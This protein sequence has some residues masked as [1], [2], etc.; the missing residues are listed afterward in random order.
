MFAALCFTKLGTVI[1][2]SGGDL[3]Y[4]LRIYGSCPALFAAFT[5]ILVVKPFSKATMSISIAELLTDTLVHRLP[6]SSADSEVCCSCDYTGCCHSQ[7]LKCPVSGFGIQMVFLVA[8]DLALTLTIIGGI[9]DFT[10]SRSVTLGMAFY[11]GLWSYAR[12]QLELCPRADNKTR[13]EN[14]HMLS[15]KMLRRLQRVCS[16]GLLLKCFN[17]AP[18]KHFC[19]CLMN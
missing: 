17:T 14:V 3:I 5:R 13:G 16:C 10:Q 2:E 1:P 12:V 9:L 7:H 8:K 19:C 18:L 15:M 11:Q 4:I 6:S